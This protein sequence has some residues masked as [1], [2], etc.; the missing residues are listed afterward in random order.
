M[1]LDDFHTKEYAFEELQPVVGGARLEVYYSGTAVLENDPRH[2]FIVQSISLPATVIDKLA[3]PL[4]YF[5]RPKRKDVFLILERPAKGDQ[6]GEAW[7]FRWLEDAI[8]QDDGANKA[9]AAELAE[10]AA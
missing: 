8:Y 4:S 3:H 1:L 9:W 7:L 5:G 2:G 6:S 10:A